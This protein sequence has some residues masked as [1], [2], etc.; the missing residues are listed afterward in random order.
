[1]TTRAF[2]QLAT[3]AAAAL[4]LVACGISA[5]REVPC[6]FPDEP[7]VCL[8]AADGATRRIAL[9][10]L[11][12]VAPETLINAKTPP[13]P[14]RDIYVQRDGTIWV[15]STGTGPEGKA[16]GR[17]G[18]IL[19]RYGPRGEPIDRRLLPEPARLI[20]RA[21]RGRAL[22]LTGTGMV[23]EVQP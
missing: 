13:R 20:L 15:I 23:A 19:A 1:M 5:T 11:S 4:N 14:I 2:D 6:W 21:E 7:V 17:G 16:R 10:G 8:I 22:V 3:G 12:R 9:A 18:W